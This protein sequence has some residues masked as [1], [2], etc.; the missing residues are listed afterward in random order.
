MQAP[1]ERG[2]R[3]VMT[4]EHSEAVMSDPYAQRRGIASKVSQAIYLIFGVVEA[5]L[6]IRFVLKLLGANA[7]AGFASFIYRISEPLVAPFVGLFGTPQVNGMVVEVE[8]LVAIVVYGLVAWGLAKLA[9]LLLG[10]TR[11]GV[12]TRSRTVDTDSR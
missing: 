2:T 3:P 6:V 7:E 10:E 12:R 9:W 5:L 8:A 11:S 1:Y 4:A